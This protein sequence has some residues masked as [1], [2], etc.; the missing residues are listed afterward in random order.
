M[1]LG[2]FQGF[3]GQIYAQNIGTFAGHG[4]RQDAAAAAHVQNA[5]PFEGNLAFNPAQAQRVDLVQGR[6]SLSVSHQRWARSE[7]LA[8][9]AG[10]KLSLVDM[11]HYR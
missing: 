4:V 7:N 1:E 2:N 5:A 3:A 10:S 9:S 6:N 8:S 11:R